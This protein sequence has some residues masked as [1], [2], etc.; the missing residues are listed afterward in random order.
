MAPR[1]FESHGDAATE[2]LG[3]RLASA[4]PAVRLITVRGELGAGKTTFVRG[5]LR[6]LGHE[7]AVKSPTFTLIELYQCGDIALCHFDL[8][9]VNDPRE[10][11]FLA[12]RDYLGS[13]NVCVV[14][15][16]ER[17]AALLPAPDIDVMIERTDNEER[18]L[19]FRAHTPAGTAALR[20]LR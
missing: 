1:R 13:D 7:G 16:P 15:W 19:T 14:E 10:L 2:A 20:E 3:R 17:A 11:E 4:L 8:Y 12:L 5:L 6:G 9:R 18:A